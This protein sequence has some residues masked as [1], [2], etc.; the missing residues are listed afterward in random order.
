MLLT[1]SS[2]D[3]NNL[4]DMLHSEIEE[5]IQVFLIR[6]GISQFINQMFFFFQYANKGRAKVHSRL[7]PI[8]RLLQRRLLLISRIRD[9]ILNEYDKNKIINL[10]KLFPLT[11]MYSIDDSSTSSKE[12]DDMYYLNA[13]ES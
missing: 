12:I 4:I 8:T 6:L 1:S 9:I 11:E 10:Q 5:F 2:Y 3:D 7:L 13:F